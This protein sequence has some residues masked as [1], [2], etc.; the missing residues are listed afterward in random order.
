M[1]T[2][3]NVRI[4]TSLLFDALSVKLGSSDFS[5]LSDASFAFRVTVLTSIF[6]LILVTVLTLLELELLSILGFANYFG[7]PESSLL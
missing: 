6:V 2:S 4:A 7:T 5:L 3:I 1:K